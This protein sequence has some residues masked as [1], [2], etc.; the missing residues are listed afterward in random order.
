M[1][2]DLLQFN[3]ATV[4]TLIFLFIFIRHNAVFEKKLAYFFDAAIVL[5]I[6][7]SFIDALSYYFSSLKTPSI[8]RKITDM[9]GYD[10]RLFLLLDFYLIIF[11]GKLK[12]RF[13]AL[14]CAV[15]LS[16]V[17]EFLG[18]FTNLV[19]H[20]SESNSFIRGPL[21]FIP[22]LTAFLAAAILVPTAI[23]KAQQNNFYEFFV[24]MAVVII[25]CTAIC[26]EILLHMNGLLKSSIALSISFYY[27]YLHMENYKLDPLTG[28]SNRRS[29]Y[30]DAERFNQK[31]A[32]MVIDLNGL[33]TLNDTEGHIEGD[34]A[35]ITLAELVS[36][37]LRKGAYLYRTGGDEFVVLCNKFGLDSVYRQRDLIK[38][39]MLTCPYTWAVGVALWH[40]GESLETVFARADADMYENKRI[41][42]REFASD[43][44]LESISKMILQENLE[45]YK[46][47]SK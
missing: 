34:K 10:F 47:L 25:N 19:F 3:F 35:I 12:K 29:F 4:A 15:S 18:L 32:L 11:R 26:F 36:K 33:K 31:T 20:Y 41:M 23:R 42:K 27:L 14:L 9:L 37:K 46:E 7:L 2:K 38:E 8:A 45:A 1:L 22:H 5:L 17:V 13:I 30:L 16:T 6:A 44:E 39:A 43:E 28:I 21:V 40:E 24:L